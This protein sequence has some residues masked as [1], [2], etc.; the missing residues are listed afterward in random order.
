[1][2]PVEYYW[3]TLILLFGLIGSARGLNKELGTT[4][5]VALSLFALYIGWSQ[6]ESLIISL[7]A[8][9]PFQLT[10]EEIKAIY[11][12]FSILFIAFL[13]YEGITLQFK[14]SLKGFLKNMFGFS[15]GYLTD[16]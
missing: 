13:A 11:Y 2:I 1:M 9:L 15:V 12:S 14:A 7:A 6:A 5:V 3:I 4:A 16:T 10:P 8:K